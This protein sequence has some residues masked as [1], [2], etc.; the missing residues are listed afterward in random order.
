MCHKK[1]SHVV[2][3]VSIVASA[4]GSIRNYAIGCVLS[5]AGSFSYL[6]LCRP[7]KTS[8]ELVSLSYWKLL[9]KET[10]KN[11]MKSIGKFLDTVCVQ[12]KNSSEHGTSIQW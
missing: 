10:L 5:I 11:K 1:K 7:A 12:F 6:K 3:R 9:L 4:Q 8:L 2:Y